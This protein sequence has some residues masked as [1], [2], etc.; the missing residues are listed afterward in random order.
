MVKDLPCCKCCA[1]LVQAPI[2]GSSEAWELVFCDLTVADNS[3]EGK[4]AAKLARKML[5]DCPYLALRERVM[6]SL[7]QVHPVE[8]LH[9]RTAMC[10]STDA[11]QQEQMSPSCYDSMLL[12]F[13]SATDRSNLSDDISCSSNLE[14]CVHDHQAL[15][16][17]I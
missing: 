16:G 4:L 9:C 1:L 10:F 3:A 7:C 14:L 17:I 6:A 15:A 13:I 5:P 12:A 8:A 11:T 2:Q